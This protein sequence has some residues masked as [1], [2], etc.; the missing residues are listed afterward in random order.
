MLTDRARIWHTILWISIEERLVYRTDFAVAT[1]M[2]FIPVVTQIFFWTAVFSAARTEKIASFTRDSM[3]AYYLLVMV[4]RALSSMPGL[5]SGI[6]LQIRDG[7][8][9]KFLIQ[10]IDLIGF[11]LLQRVAHKLIYY[12]VAFIPFAVVFF[13]ARGFFPGWPEPEVLAAYFAALTMSFLIGFFLEA[14]IGL[15]GFWFLEVTSLLFIY[16]LLNFILSGHMFPLDLVAG[17]SETAAMLIKALPLYYLAGFPAEV[18]LGIA[19]GAELRRGLW[20]Q[21]GWVLVF[22]IL[23]RASLHYGVRRYSGFGG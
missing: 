15:I 20:I 7:E 2:R 3:I 17:W 8:I 21:F 4:S 18:F 11:L 23:C 9:K 16:M 6:A 5:A 1:L 14:T 12:L 22:L 13:V 10:P 19:D